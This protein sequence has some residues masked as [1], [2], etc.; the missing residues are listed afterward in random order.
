MGNFTRAN[1]LGWG[2]KTKLTSDQANKLDIDHTKAPNF[3][4]GSSHAPTGDIELVG[5]SAGGLVFTGFR[6]EGT[7]VG[8]GG[9]VFK[10]PLSLD[11]AAYSLQLLNGADASF[12]NG[13]IVSWSDGAQAS[14]AN[15][16]SAFFAGVGHHIVDGGRVTVDDN[17]EI[18]VAAGGLLDA[19]YQS[20]TKL[21][22]A[23]LVGD[24]VHADSGYVQ[25]NALS[26]LHCV[27]GSVVTGKMTLG[28]GGVG[29]TLAVMTASTVQLFGTAK[30]RVGVVNT[31]AATLELGQWSTFTST[32]TLTLGATSA[33]AAH[34]AI[35]LEDGATLTVK[36]N[37]DITY[38]A[39]SQSHGAHED[40]SDFTRTV[41]GPTVY[42]GA[43][44]YRRWRVTSVPANAS[45]QLR[46]EAQ[47]VI[48]LPEVS[49]AQILSL[50]DAGP[51]PPDGCVVRIKRRGQNAAGTV[52]TIE[53]GAGGTSIINLEVSGWVDA[54]WS[55]SAGKWIPIGHGGDVTGPFI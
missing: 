29:A 47:D 1:P 55:S 18:V 44:G 5:P 37:S 50:L 45:I 35:T 43:S 30:L 27:D 12:G 42:S 8:G 21:Y 22:G 26:V 36:A 4:E 14:F 25:L 3:D 39:G 38:Q 34:G 31:D 24:A 20:T 40:A 41:K 49:T 54:M 15:G 28:S 2:V 23:V 51:E 19:Q 7:I 6:V 17:G 32:G 13:S 9:L 33:L 16:S 11:G 46:G 52:W 53:S 10:I 48:L